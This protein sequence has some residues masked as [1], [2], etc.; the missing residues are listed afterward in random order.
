MDLFIHFHFLGF[1]S[2][3]LTVSEVYHP[4]Y[5]CSESYEVRPNVGAIDAGLVLRTV[6]SLHG[7]WVGV[8]RLGG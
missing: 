4:C 5:G 3:P 2:C 7:P 8:K 1:C 6:P